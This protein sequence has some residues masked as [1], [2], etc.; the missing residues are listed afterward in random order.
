MNVNDIFLTGH[1][2]TSVSKFG[3]DGDLIVEGVF[4]STNR[5]VDGD[6]FDKDFLKSMTKSLN[7]NRPVYLNHWYHTAPIGKVI[8]AV[9]EELEDG[10]ALVKGTVVVDTSDDDL[11]HRIN[12]GLIR[13]FSVGGHVT[14]TEMIKSSGKDTRLLKE[15]K[16][17]ELSLTPVPINIGAAMAV[18]KGLISDID[19][20][21]VRKNREF[22]KSI[23]CNDGVCTV[24]DF[25]DNV[26]FFEDSNMNKGNVSNSNINSKKTI[27]SEHK[28][29]VG[30]GNE[31]EVNM[32]SAETMR[33]D[34]NVHSQSNKTAENDVKIPPRASDT[35][36]EATNQPYSGNN[37]YFEQHKSEIIE[38]GD[39]DPKDTYDD[40]IAEE[41]Y[42]KHN[43]NPRGANY[44]ED[45]GGTYPEDGSINSVDEASNRFIRETNEISG[46]KSKVATV[47]KAVVST[48]TKGQFAEMVNDIFHMFK[49]SEPYQTS[50]ESKIEALHRFIEQKDRFRKGSIFRQ[51]MDD[52]IA[53]M[54][55]SIKNVDIKRDSLDGLLFGHILANHQSDYVNY[56]KSVMDR[57]KINKSD[58]GMKKAEM[59]EEIVEEEAPTAE[60]IVEEEAM[61]EEPAPTEAPVEPAVDGGEDV[62]AFYQAL[63]QDEAVVAIAQQLEQ[64]VQAGDEA[65]IQELASQLYMEMERIAQEMGLDDVPAEVKDALGMTEQE[66]VD[67][68]M[69]IEEE[70][71]GKGFSDAEIRKSVQDAITEARQHARPKS[72]VMQ[73]SVGSAVAARNA[74]L[75][76]LA[77][78]LANFTRQFS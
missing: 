18:S 57:D 3:T 4:A 69:G 15:G 48:L 42:A 56:V 66:P 77:N 67:G 6:V 12:Q 37:E 14:D 45:G 73:K 30:S 38:K 23:I 50:N 74:E 27:D 75:D 47:T 13:Y 22:I 49:S 71:F 5:D 31:T 70:G 34:I 61:T 11:K 28:K 68:G 19:F 55:K 53:H 16:V 25:N 41:E 26:I 29:V 8:K 40:K 54:I 51:G 9:Y 21:N 20:E 33:S 62:E 10:S 59:E 65:Q 72:R 39:L 32:P 58:C 2:V 78:Q 35:M 52:E 63:E 76:P 24:H 60:E 46:S 1:E 44:Y 7:Q 64:A 36:S 43:S 17:L